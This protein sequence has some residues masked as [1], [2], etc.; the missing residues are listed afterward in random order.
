MSSTKG[1]G[2]SEDDSKAFSSYYSTKKPEE[3]TFLVILGS[4]QK[5]PNNAV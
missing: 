4:G 5:F 3:K 2:V 1:E